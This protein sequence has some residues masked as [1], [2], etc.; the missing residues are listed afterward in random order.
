MLP[1]LS[2]SPS[3]S[4]RRFVSS[5]VAAAAA[6]QFAPKL[7]AFTAATCS[8]TP[9][10]EQGPFYVADELSRSSIADG[11]PGIP[12]HLHLTFVDSRTCKPLPNAAIDLWHCDAAGLYAG[13][14]H[15]SMGPGPGS[16]PN[17]EAGPPPQSP[18]PEGAPFPTRHASHPGPPPNGGPPQMKPTDHL[19]FCRGIQLTDMQGVATFHTIFPGFYQGRVNHI[20][21]KVRIGGHRNGRHFAAGHTAH[22][23]QIFFPEDLT[24][25]LMQHEPYRSHHIDR[26]TAAQDG[27]FNG[28]G[29]TQSVAALASMATGY[30]A[31]LTLTVDP[32]ATPAAVGM[33]G[34]PPQD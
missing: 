5:S 2:Q 23:G 11:H 21:M 7:Y 20:H 15:V 28:Q 18:P 19:T 33:G 29:G 24:V 22:T 26:T 14:T 25:K 16:G 32:T 12:L 10:Q 1:S 6:L 4:R 3:I 27:I 8:L 9:E 30:R 34:P 17:G 31:E 13:Y